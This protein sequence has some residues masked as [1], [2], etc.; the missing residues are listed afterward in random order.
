MCTQAHRSTI[1][2]TPLCLAK[3]VKN[4]TEIQGMKTAHVRML[5]VFIKPHLRLYSC[6]IMDARINVLSSSWQIKDAVALCDLFAWLEKE[7]GRVLC[8]SEL[9]QISGAAFRQN[10]QL[11]ADPQPVAHCIGSL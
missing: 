7:V 11:K 2:Y 4:T 6:I 10:S 8:L 3:A 9:R 1:P 5:N